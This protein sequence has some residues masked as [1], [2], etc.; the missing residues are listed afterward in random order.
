MILNLNA[1]PF[2]A[3]I[4]TIVAVALLSLHHE[5]TPTMR[6]D[7]ASS[8]RDSTTAEH[9]PVPAPSIDPSDADTPLASETPAEPCETAADD[10]QTQDASHSNAHESTQNGVVE[11]DQLDSATA[12]AT[13]TGN[14]AIRHDHVPTLAPPPAQRP[15]TPYLLWWNG[16]NGAMVR[17]IL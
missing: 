8:A 12:E 3:A 15:S 16:I 6:T 14:D 7:D 13:P 17:T 2:P 4:D 1:P 10:I 11:G 9:L 5:A